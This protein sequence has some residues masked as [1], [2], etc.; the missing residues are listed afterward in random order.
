MWEWCK[1]KC[2][3]FLTKL[4]GGLM[5][6]NNVPYKKPLHSDALGMQPDDVAEHREKFPDIEIDSEN[7]PVFTHMRQH[8]AY[9]EEVGVHKPQQ[10]V[11]LGG[12]IISMLDQW[13]IRVELGEENAEAEKRR[14]EKDEGRVHED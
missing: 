10:K 14:D 1:K 2:L 9:M 12:T 3:V 8:D 4:G 11:R 5:N 13:G 7:R 6:I